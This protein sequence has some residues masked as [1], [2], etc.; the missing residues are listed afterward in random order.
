MRVA[1]RVSVQLFDGVATTASNVRGELPDVLAD[2]GLR[3]VSVRDR[4]RTPTGSYEVMT[5][6]HP[7]AR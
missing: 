6:A 2:A 5:G 1:V 3:G 7:V 4:L